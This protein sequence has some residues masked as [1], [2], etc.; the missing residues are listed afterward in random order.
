MAKRKRKRKE[1]KEK[2]KVQTGNEG[3]RVKSTQRIEQPDER[4]T[5]GCQT[6][7]GASPFAKTELAG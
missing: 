4:R 7:A 2:R 5:E 1:R 6:E 3:K